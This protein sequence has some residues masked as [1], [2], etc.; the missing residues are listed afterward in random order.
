MN[1]GGCWASPWAWHS[2][3]WR[4]H[5]HT[6]ARSRAPHPSRMRLVLP[7]LDTTDPEA[8]LAGLRS[9]APLPG[10]D[11]PKIQSS[12]PHMRPCPGRYAAGTGVSWSTIPWLPAWR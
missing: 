2:P 8:L 10:V 5:G 12:A 9:T 11:E 1:F 4:S 3:K 7:Y 6:A